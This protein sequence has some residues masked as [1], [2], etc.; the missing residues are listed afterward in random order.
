MGTFTGKLNPNKIF[1]ALFNMIISQQ[2]FSDNIKGTFS[3]LVDSARTDGT[4]YGD[5][6][7]YYATDVLKS[8]AWGADA[9]AA[10]LLKLYR[11][12]APEQQKITLDVFRQ[13]PLT[14]DNYLSKQAW[15]DETAV[16]QFNSVMIG[17]MRE[18]KKVYD[19]TIYNS[20][21]GTSESQ[22]EV[23]EVLVDKSTYPTLGQ[24]IGEVIADLF[25]DLEDATRKFNEYKFLRSYD[26][27]DI[28]VVWNSK[29]VNQVKKIDL[30][31]LFHN[32]G[33]V[34]KFAEDVLPARYFGKPATDTT[35]TASTR[36][37]VEVDLNTVEPSQAGYKPELHLFPGDKL[38]VG[39]DV[40]NIPHY[41]ED[42]NVICKVMHNESVPYM[43]A[44]EVETSFYN[45]K[46]LTDNRYL[47]FGHNTLEYLKDK[48]MLT[49]RLKSE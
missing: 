8:Y 34:M 17:W 48:P 43:S 46:S 35:A 15:S 11:P 42:P 5:T 12:K 49:V 9:E 24:G 44:F 37:L 40:T 38:P 36:S 45:A 18:T 26:E 4:L 16:M 25:V 6:K 31:A 1:A 29:F 39:T 3:K 41:D 2:V 22:A 33:L 7:I 27:G 10:N 32:E 13:I 23:H 47:T 14:V 20:F 21:I 19:S 28:K 30:P